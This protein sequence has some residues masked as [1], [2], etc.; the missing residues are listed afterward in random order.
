MDVL[1]AKYPDLT[2]TGAADWA[3]GPMKTISAVNSS[4]L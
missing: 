2:E 1:L 4:R 3:D